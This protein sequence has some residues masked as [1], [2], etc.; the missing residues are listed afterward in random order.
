M[1]TGSTDH[2]VCEHIDG[3]NWLVIYAGNKKRAGS[4]ARVARINHPGKKFC[5]AYSLNKGCGDC[6]DLPVP[7]GCNV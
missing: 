4:I 2:L 3:R 5:L 6:I 1:I 7:A